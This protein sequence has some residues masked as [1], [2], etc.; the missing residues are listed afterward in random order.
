MNLHLIKKVK[1]SVDTFDA[2]SKSYADRMLYK[3][4]IGNIPNTVTTDPILFTFPVAKAFASGKII[5]CVR[6]G[7]N[8]WQMSGLQNQVQCSQLRG[9]AFTS[10]PEVRPL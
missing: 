8:G 3:T 2:V 9:V 1:S 10:F 7:L 4:A 6:C 5:I